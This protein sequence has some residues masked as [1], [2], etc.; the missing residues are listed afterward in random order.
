ML[1]NNIYLNSKIKFLY[2]IVQEYKRYGPAIFI[3]FALQT[4]NFFIYFNGKDLLMIF[5]LILI[6][7]DHIQTYFKFCD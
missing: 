6:D 2:I 1:P 4:A 3:S 7:Y 5:R